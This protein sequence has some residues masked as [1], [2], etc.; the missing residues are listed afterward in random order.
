MEEGGDLLE[1]F[2]SDLVAHWQ[3]PVWNRRSILPTAR[4]VHPGL[5]TERAGQSC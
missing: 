3:S 2:G 5:L 1:L 4:Q